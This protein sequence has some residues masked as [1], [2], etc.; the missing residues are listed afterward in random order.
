MLGLHLHLIILNRQSRI[1]LIDNQLLLKLDWRSLIPFELAV[2]GYF[3]FLYLKQSPSSNGV[4]A[5]N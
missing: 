2:E 3:G 4:L 1:G 5:A